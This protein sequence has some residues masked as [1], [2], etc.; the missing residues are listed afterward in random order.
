MPCLATSCTWSSSSLSKFV[1]CAWQ[2]LVPTWTTKSLHPWKVYLDLNLWKWFLKVFCVAS[3]SSPHQWWCQ[4]S[5]C[6]EDEENSRNLHHEHDYCYQW[7][8]T[9]YRQLL[10]VLPFDVRTL[11]VWCLHTW[12]SPSFPPPFFLFQTYHTR[13]LHREEVVVHH[14]HIKKYWDWP[15]ARLFV[16]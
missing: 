12:V 2:A 4:I 11:H 14:P 7:I 16:L 9:H 15:K 10:V 8:D 6:V 5:S 1:L 13:K 3:T